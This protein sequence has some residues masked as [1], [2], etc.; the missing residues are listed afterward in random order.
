MDL[1]EKIR[2]L[3][4][5]VIEDDKLLRESTL[6]F[7]RSKGCAIAGYA[8]A[9]SAM[10]D[11]KEVPPD[12]VI[13]DYVLPGTDGLC[14]L[15]QVGELLPKTLRILV[16]GHPSPDITCEVEKAGIDGFI[17]KPFSVIEMED[18]LRRLLEGRK[19]NLPEPS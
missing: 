19:A 18:A 8:D 17:L 13:S 10:N 2:S 5:A 12:I 15:R 14:L 4:L 16:T 3:K 7:F 9:D 11:F 6:L 1:Y